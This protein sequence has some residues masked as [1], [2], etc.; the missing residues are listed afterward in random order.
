VRF[1]LTLAL[2]PNISG[3]LSRL[4]AVLLAHRWV[5]AVVLFYLAGA[6]LIAHSYGVPGRISVLTYGLVVPKITAIYLFFFALFYLV[7]VMVV[8]RPPRLIGYVVA[9]VA[10][11]WLSIQRLLGGLVMILVLQVFFSAFSSMKAL[12]PIMNPF[13]WDATFAEWDRALHGGR[14][15]WALIQPLLGYPAVTTAINFLYQCWLFVLYGFLVWQ[16]FST[17]DQRLR[18]QFFLAL[19]LLWALLGN[20]AATVFSSAGPVYFGRA[21]GLPDPFEPL[22]SYLRAANEVSPVWALDIHDRLWTAYITDSDQLGK[23]ISAMPSIHVATAVLFALTAWRASRSPGIVF[24]AYAVAVMIGSVHLA[25]HYALDGYISI[26]LTY[27]I[28]R[29][30]GWWAARDGTLALG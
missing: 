11:N 16:A 20:L 8:Q 12:I 28:W 22:I 19:L 5:I 13:A 24:A 25:W 2:S 3:Y 17:R 29:A 30:A 6:Y 10:K 15:P 26:V 23:G 27:L 9:D 21:T 14:D 1:V 4:A 18:M 7:Y